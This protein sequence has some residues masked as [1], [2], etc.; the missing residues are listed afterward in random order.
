MMPTEIG[1]LP[2][3][4][5]KSPDGKFAI[6]TDMGFHESLWSVDTTTGA[7]ISEV[8][9]QNT[10]NQPH[11]DLYHGLA[12]APGKGP[13]YTLYAAQGETQTVA[14]LSL[15]SAGQLTL[16]GSIPTQAGDL[17]SGLATDDNG[18]LYVANNDP[19][20][21][22][23]PGSVAIYNAAGTEVGRYKFTGSFGGTPNFP[24]AITTLHGGTKTYVASQRDSSV[25]VL[26]TQRSDQPQAAEADRY[27]FAPHGTAAEQI[28]GLVIR[29][30]RAQRHR[31]CGFDQY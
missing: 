30:Q 17:P 1:S 15:S 14:I 9:F 21:F 25:Y 8:Q 28:A 22:A 10:T 16:A 2:M 13:D 19:D 18:Y 23:A 26:D 20:T 12:F 31:L 5:I 27:R 11:Y 6:T 29:S 24:L 4:I 3:N 7:T